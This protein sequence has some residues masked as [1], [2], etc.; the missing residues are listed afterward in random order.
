[1]KVAKL[2]DQDD[3]EAFLVTFERL[4]EA[5]EVPKA[6]WAYKLATQLSGRAQQAYAAMP[7]EISGDYDEVKSAILRRYDITEETY[8]QRFR[9]ASKKEGETYRELS[10]RLLDLANLPC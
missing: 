6:R 4:M 5:Y 2:T 10:M 9:A 7:S 1:M 8:R 3:T